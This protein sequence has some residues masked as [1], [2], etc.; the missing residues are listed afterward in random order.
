MKRKIE[1][2]RCV[3]EDSYYDVGIALCSKCDYKCNTCVDFPDK[4]LTCISGTF[5]IA[6]KVNYQCNCDIGFFDVGTEIC[7][8]KYNYFI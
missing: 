4:C 3:C 6:D 5:R 8:G 1:E 7:A 2:N